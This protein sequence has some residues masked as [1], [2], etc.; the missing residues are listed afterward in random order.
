MKESIACLTPFSL[1]QVNF[2]KVTIPLYCVL[3]C[4]E[5]KKISTTEA[6]GNPNSKKE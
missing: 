4:S 6:E 2:S 5:K 1:V 3:C